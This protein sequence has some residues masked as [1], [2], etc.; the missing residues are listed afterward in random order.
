MAINKKNLVWIDLEMTGL[1]VKV[2]QIIEIS[3]IVTNSNLDIIAQ[4][5][6]LV[7]HANEEK[8]KNMDK[9]NTEHHTASGLYKECL[10]SK[11]TN[12]IAE[13]EAIKFLK[14]YVPKNTSPL[15]GN[16]V[17]Q[18]RKFLSKDMPKLE[19]Y[20]HYRNLDVTSLKIL[21]QRWA[22]K[23]AKLVKKKSSHRASDD[24]KE[25]IYELQ[26]Y[27]DNFLNVES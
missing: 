27:K 9:W 21:A 25:S 24:I 18:D 8:L 1:D 14:Q 23:I 4:F 19:E 5:P 17:W 15:C 3:I 2:D 22:P 26:V 12:E 6:S 11:I 10:E 13:E 7:I 16:S 20:F